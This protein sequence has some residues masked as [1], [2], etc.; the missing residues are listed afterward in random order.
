M[1]A[2]VRL[3]AYLLL[4]LCLEPALVLAQSDTATVSGLVTDSK[5]AVLV[6]AQVRA[7]NVEAGTRF[8][9]LTNQN[10]VYV[11]RNLRPGQYR[12]IVDNQG[13]QQIVLVGLVLS[14]QDAVGRNFTMQIG[15]IIQSLTITA[16][17][18]AVNISP[19][20]GTVVNPQFVENLP[21][22]GRSFQSLIGLTPGVNFVSTSGGGG[23]GSYGE[24]S[25]NGQRTNSTYFTVD[26][27]SANSA[28]SFLFDPGQTLG[29]TLPSLTVSGGTNGLL[30]VDA[31]QE[32]RVQTST[33]APEY[34]RSPA[35]IS[36]VTRSG[37][38][39]FHGTVYDYLR[40]NALD[41]RNYF[42]RPPNP[43]PPLRQNDFGGTLGGPL[44]RNRTFFF[45]SYEGLRL[46]L[47][48]TATGNFYTAAAR[49]DVAPPYQP[50]MASL[51]LPDGPL[52]SDGLTA[53][54][55][56]GYSD[57]TS[58]DAY[59]LR[60]DHTINQHLSLFGRYNHA[61]ST[62]WRRFWSEDDSYTANSDSATLGATYVSPSG[63]V[64]DFRGNWS[65]DTGGHV[66]VM[67]SFHG[68]VPPPDSAMFPPGY[69]SGTSQFGFSPPGTSG[70]IEKGREVGNVQKQLNFID[71]FSVTARAHQLKFGADFRHLNPATDND[72][73]R[74]SIAANTYASLQAGIVDSVYNIGGASI[75]TAIDN[76]SFFAQDIWKVSPRVTLT[77]GLRWEINTPMRSV[78]P[79]KP[80]YAVTGIF[81]SAPFGLAP[82]GTPLWHTRFDNFAPRAGAA[83]QFTPQTVLRGGF[84]RY[85]DLGYGGG[86]SGTMIWFP[87]YTADGVSGPIPFNLT[88]RAFQPPGFTLTPGM[89]TAYI[90]AVDPHL[91]VPFTYEWNVAVQRGLGVNQSVSATYV[92]AHGDNLLREDTIISTAAYDTFAT[93][94]GDWSNYNALQLQFQR[95]MARGFQA[96]VSYT[97][98]K[99][100]DTASDDT[101]GGI[102]TTSLSN[103]NV[104][105]DLG[106]SRFDVRNSF[107]A[108]VSWQ[109][110]SPR[111]NGPSDALLRN[112][113]IDS[114]VRIS[115][116]TPYGVRANVNS[117]IFYETRPDIVPGVP[118]YLAVPGQ[119]G[120][121]S[122]NP[123]AFTAPPA[124]QYG[125]LP[126]NYFRGFPIDQTD[127][128]LRRQ[129][130]LTERASLFLGAE[131]FNVFN[132][133][134]FAAALNNTVLG[135]PSFG[136]ITQTLNE[137][138]GVLNPLYQ[139]GGPRSGQLTIKILF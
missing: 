11:L 94:N 97:L 93:H 58:L 128:S 115:S 91:K 13:L 78:T 7:V 90:D 107:S 118:F 125:D 86:L 114:I 59:S 127:L 122:L 34:G 16:S 64:N 129:F 89:G 26:G 117:P 124:G 29:G 39:Q 100:T 99:S 95:R 56:V 126:R 112:W 82:A 105:S 62:E 46:L 28:S 10:G 57:P 33:F 73:Y 52:N 1:T 69:G 111:W 23:G 101:D 63:L 92:G 70:E 104:A 131:Y 14:A 84:G 6:G 77:Y 108:A 135:Y 71:N 113:Q 31:M 50:L 24:F 96:L 123:A 4:A 38:G 49:Q 41:A 15:S 119:P 35:Q 72:N 53:P 5:G 60:I 106:P 19:A 74:F 25:V 102:W 43:V 139:I 8:D 66:V 65:R 68:A 37:T 137:D 67:D 55:T 2:M 130:H 88:N 17:G 12:L 75:T 20:V 87:Y 45:F 22:N 30:S 136:Q 18:Q 85:Y 103:V 76:Y 3:V 110:P 80:L 40:N 121:R 138:L 83:F 36:I 120:G 81:D 32:F 51:P 27:V 132:H 61:P 42:D 109:I 21:L 9:V 98:A 47:P 134:M 44:V 54:L 48:Q 116:P 79:G 133:P